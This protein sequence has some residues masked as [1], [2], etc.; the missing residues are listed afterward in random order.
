[1]G[2]NG[3]MTFT[4]NQW[5]LDVAKAVPLQK[6]LLETDAPFLTPYPFR[7]TVNEP[8]HVRAVAQFLSQLRGESLQ[9][10]ASTTT[11][12]AHSLFNTK[13]PKTSQ[14]KRI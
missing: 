7:G 14:S 4:K 11:Q 10:I 13:I 5:Q 9:I 2:L 1:I 8:A 12:N 6:L 3:I